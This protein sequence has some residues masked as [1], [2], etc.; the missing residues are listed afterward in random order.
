MVFTIY[1]ETPSK[2]NSRV[3]NTKTRRS[4]PNKRYAQWH[5]SA[6]AQVFSALQNGEIQKIPLGSRVEL[7]LTFYHGDLKR[8]DSDNQTSSVLDT[9]TDA[10]IL[11][12]DNWKVIPIKHIYDAYDKGKA[13][14]V[15]SL[16]II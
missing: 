3:L 4:F 5:D 12:D 10:G 9:L 13:R 1:G 6:V 15:V 14:C 7:T 8:R 16:E 2:K 11:E